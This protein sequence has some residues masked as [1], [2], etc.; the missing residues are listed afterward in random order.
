MARAPN[1]LFDHF[2]KSEAP[3][4]ILKCPLLLGFVGA[5]IPAAVTPFDPF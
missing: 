1:F 4:L 2:R 5:K 3:L